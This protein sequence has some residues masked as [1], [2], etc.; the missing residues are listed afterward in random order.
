MIFFQAERDYQ[1]DVFGCIMEKCRIQTLSLLGTKSQ[2]PLKFLIF[3][4]KG[5]QHYP[6]NQHTFNQLV[7]FLL[8]TKVKIKN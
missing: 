3:Y 5:C 4:F 1:K 2:A 8:F 6:F 7:I